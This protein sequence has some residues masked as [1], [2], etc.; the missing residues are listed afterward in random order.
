MHKI[1]S[2]EG[3]VSGPEI[4]DNDE[5][6]QKYH[7]A[8]EEMY[9]TYYHYKNYELYPLDKWLR[10]FRSDKYTGP[11]RQYLAKQLRKLHKERE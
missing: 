9:I 11:E 6:Y 8:I 3:N 2:Q 10:I 4:L 1:K 5:T 7:E